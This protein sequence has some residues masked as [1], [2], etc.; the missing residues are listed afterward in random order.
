MRRDKR[1]RERERVDIYYVRIE[2]EWLLLLLLKI[3]CKPLFLHINV[4]FWNVAF[5]SS[6]PFEKRPL[7]ER[8][9]NKGGKKPPRNM[10]R[11]TNIRV[12]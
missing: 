7:S 12:E 11:E 1:E 4:M 3:N 2:Y 10:M 9:G 6:Y 8:G 5:V